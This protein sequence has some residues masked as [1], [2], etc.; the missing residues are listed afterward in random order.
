M[1]GK[2]A[3]MYQYYGKD[4][5]KKRNLAELLRA[6]SEVEGI[7]WIRLHYAYPSGFPLDV[8]DE[9]R[10]NP[11]ICNYIDIPLQHISDN[12]LKIMRRG[13]NKKSTYKLIEAFRKRVP[14]MAIR[15]TLL[16]GHPGETE[17]D[18]EQLCQFIKDSKLDRVGV[19]TYSHEENTHAFRLED[20]VSNDIKSQRASKVMEVQSHISYNL[21]IG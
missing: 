19:F 16:V 20:D 13:T 12:V 4:L 2:N 1:N 17:D 14:E 5:Y 21:N 3:D 6:L 15:T 8:L 10:E 18:F 11:K 7:E 9:M